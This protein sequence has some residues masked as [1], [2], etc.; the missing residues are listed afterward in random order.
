MHKCISIHTM[1]AILLVLGLGSAQAASPDSFEPDHS[2]ADPAPDTPTQTLAMAL[3]KPI[4]VKSPQL[5]SLDTGGDI[6]IADRDFVTFAL[7]A[8]DDVLVEA[9]VSVG[10]GV[11]VIRLF[12]S[13]GTQIAIANAPATGTTTQLFAKNL[14]AGTYYAGVEEAGLVSGSAQTIE[15]YFLT[16][17][18][19]TPGA[20][21]SPVISNPLT[22]TG[23]SGAEFNFDLLAA[24]SG[25]IAFTAT[26][27]PSGLGVN[28]ATITGTPRQAGTFNV[29]LNA[30]NGTAPDDSKTLVL[31]ISAFGIISTVA[32]NGVLGFSGDDDLALN[33]EFNGLIGLTA[34]PAGN[35]FVADSANNRVRKIDATT[36]TID[37]VVG[38]GLLPVGDNGAATASILNAPGQIATDAA[39]N[40]YIADAG[41]NRIRKLTVATGVITTLV[42]NGV[43]G[44]SPDGVSGTLANLKSPSGIAVD[45]TGANLYFTDTSNHLVRM[46]KNGQ[47]VTLAGTVVAGVPTA[48]SFGDGG[49]ANLASLNS[50]IGLA[51]DT[52]NSLL[53]VADTGNNRVRVINL[54]LATPTIAAFAGT[55]GAGFSGGGGPA[56][57]AL[58]NVPRGVNLDG[59]GHVFIADSGNNVIRAVTLSTGNVSLAAGSNIG[60]S[61]SSGDGGL[62]TSALLNNPSTI[63]INGTQILV[64]DTGNHRIRQFTLAGNIMPLAGTGTSGFG[65]DG[66]AATA[67]Q[68]ATPR[69]VAV[70]GTTVYIADTNN[71]RIRSVAGGN[72]STVAGGGIPGDGGAGTNVFINAP[73]GLATDTAGNIYFADTGNRRVRKFTAATG[74]V[75]TVAGNGATSFGGDGGPAVNAALNSPQGVVLDAAGN[76]YI[77]DTQNSRIRMVNAAGTISTFA[78]IGTNGFSGDTGPATAAQLNRPNSLTLD[79]AGNMYIADTFNNAIRKIAAGSGNISTVAGTGTTTGGFAGDG[80]PATAAL[81]FRP[82]AVAVDASG[83]LYIADNG[84]SRIRRVDAATGIITTFSGDGKASFSGDGG[85]ASNA[86]LSGPQA[87]VF[88]AAGSLYVTDAGNRR[89]RKI[90]VATAPLI[91][92]PATAAGVQSAFFSYRITGTGNPAPSFSASNLPDGLFYNNGLISGFPTGSGATDIVL[93]ASNIFGTTNALLRL[94]LSKAG[95]GADQAPT[96]NSPP[97]AITI[98]PNPGVTAQP[99]VFVA[100]STGDG[101]ADLLAYDWNFG[102]GQKGSGATTSHAYA[103]VGVYT[104]TVTAT[105]GV[106][107]ISAS[108]PVAINDPSVTQT[109]LITKAGF[110]FNFTKQ[111]AD[112]VTL[113]GTVP[114]RTGFTP[115]GKTVTLFVGSLSR[116][117]ALNAKGGVTSKTDVIKLTASQKPG[118]FLDV[119]K[120]FY[121]GKFSIT[122]KGQTLNNTLASLG[123]VKNVL[124]PLPLRVPVLLSV[125]SDSYVQNLTV[126]YKSTLTSGSG[127]KLNDGSTIPGR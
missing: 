58:F 22:A 68:L 112:S 81:L 102:D 110:K 53:Y 4:A 47:V 66:A 95:G 28:G 98:T 91:T 52:V 65:G 31:N 6:T 71:Q 82:R 111:N 49:A 60:K 97:V 69:G 14:A 88:D 79:A 67:A 109:V 24:G 116:T 48:G 38:N 30:S 61:G 83:N 7:T 9:D 80:G 101:D 11:T 118:A 39:G 29:T 46:L 70:A 72:I 8:T 33:A 93:T 26:G 86:E 121:A 15:S 32:G 90:A 113:M 45:A 122:L 94:T 57:N 127:S 99:I 126:V 42:G 37:T 40:V 13:A 100:P 107:S 1:L 96:F 54:A 12:N 16:L 56:V 114:L 20:S 59:S 74:I 10:P 34:D 75:T 51:L 27:L 123:F 64:V 76:L 108:A 92:S 50:P 18:T 120:Q 44:F 19:V 117:F 55:G 124:N 89:V 43:S 3:P 35:V 84:N 106:A 17:E 104:V 73:Q 103:A 21:F 105:D 85:A 78:G 23:V 63:G 77:A 36:Q 62:A 41:N 87:L 5:H 115:S 119:A 2:L 25:P 125:G